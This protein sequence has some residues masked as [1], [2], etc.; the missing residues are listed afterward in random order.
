MEIFR[1]VEKMSYLSRKI[2]EKITVN[3]ILKAIDEAIE[4]LKNARET[5]VEEKWETD[6]LRILHTKAKLAERY[7]DEL[8][9]EAF[10][11]SLPPE[12]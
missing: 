11:R 12:A 9:H 8:S 7:A 5:I 4:H 2:A 1:E 3:D 6:D 10:I